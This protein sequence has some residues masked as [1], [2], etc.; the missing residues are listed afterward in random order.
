MRA[1]VF[2]S[3]GSQKKGMGKGL[4]DRFRPLVERADAIL[5]H[6][7]ETLCVEDPDRRL[8]QTEFAQPAIYVVNALHHLQELERNPEP[9]DYFAGHSLGEYNALLAAGAFDFETGLKLVQRRAALMAKLDGGGMAAVVGAVE[10]AITDVLDQH[11]AEGVTIANYNAPYEFVLSGPRDG[12]ARLRPIFEKVDGVKAFVALRTSGA[13]HSAHMKAARDAFQSHLASVDF[14]ELSRP[15]I[16]NVTARPYT[17]DTLRSLLAEQITAPVRW[18]E[19]IRYLREAGVSRFTELGEGKVLSGLIGKILAE[20]PPTT[21]AMSPQ[22]QV[23][24][25][26]K[27]QVLVPEL[28]EAA[29]ELEAD[30]PFRQLGLDSLK[31]IRLARRAE[32]VFGIPFKPATFY[33]ITTSAAMADYVIEQGAGPQEAPPPKVDE[34]RHRWSEHRDSEV[35]RLLR[36]CVRGVRSLESTAAMIRAGLY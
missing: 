7:I 33:S 2:P 20:P 1:C 26:L 31:Y 9:P 22:E 24:A 36:E 32:T 27:E 15:V 6:S 25:M 34:T 18:S 19:S 3:Q 16:S 30:R 5:G 35:L 28:G 10:K 29:R 23:V 21:A 12:L 4:F 14:S 17:K 13:F 8:L 11:A